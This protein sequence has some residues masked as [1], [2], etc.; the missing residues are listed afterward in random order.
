[1]D[2]CE[3][4]HGMEPWLLREALKVLE[5]EEKVRSI[6]VGGWWLLGL[7]VQPGDV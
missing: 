3:D 2:V 1:M 4:I 5:G 7:M 6:A